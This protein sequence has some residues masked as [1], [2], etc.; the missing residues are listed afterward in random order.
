[1][2]KYTDEEVLKWNILAKQHRFCIEQECQYYYHEIDS[3]ML[4]EVDVPNDWE[5]KCIT[6]KEEDTCKK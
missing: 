5:K 4:G 6:E 2:K 1:M 3:C